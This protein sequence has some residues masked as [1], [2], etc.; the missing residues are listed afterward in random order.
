MEEKGIVFA[1]KFFLDSS[2]LSLSSGLEGHETARKK[3]KGGKEKEKIGRAI[4]ILAKF[5]R[6]FPFS[7]LSLLSFLGPAFRGQDK[8][9]G[10]GKWR[11]AVSVLPYRVSIF[12]FS[13]MFPFGA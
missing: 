12:T 10:E 7:L 6:P 4:A 3:G 13:V 1:A 9:R 11:Q 8:E 5:S 2:S